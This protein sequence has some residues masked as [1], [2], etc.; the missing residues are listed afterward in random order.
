MKYRFFARGLAILLL[1][2]S[3][4]MAA[5][6]ADVLPAAKQWAVRPLAEIMRHQAPALDREVLA[7]EDLDRRDQGLP[8]R[9]AQNQEVSLTPDAAGNWETLPGGR[10]LWR[11]RVFCP[12]V[13]SLNLGF[14]R[15]WLPA[16]ARLLVYPAAEPSPVQVYDETDIA[17][18][19]QLWT[20]VLLTDE[21]VIELEVDAALRWQVEI[22]LTSIG[23]GYRLFGEDFTEKSG[24]CNVD[25]VC[26]EGDDWRDEID[27]VGGYSFGGSLFCTGFMINNTDQDGT[28]Y[29]MTAY[30]CDVR[31]NLAP[32]LVVYWNFQKPDCSMGSGSLTQFQNGATLRAEYSVS[33]MALLELDDL[34]ES[35]FNV[36]Y[37]GWN[38]ATPPPT[39]AVCIHHPSG[40]EKSIS[41]END[42]VT[43][44]SYQ[45]NLS[46]GDGTHLRV[47]DWDVGT[48][49]P[50]SSGSPLF[51]QDHRVVGQ[52]H[53]GAAACGNNASDWYGRF[54]T[55]WTGGGTPATQLSGWLDPQDTGA[56]TVDTI[57]PRGTSFTVAP[58]AGFESA[59]VQG[60]TFEPMSMV[61]TL[62]NTGDETA[63]FTAE[64]A[65]GW[66]TVTPAGGSIAIGGTVEVE[67]SFNSAADNLA[68]G[69]HQSTLLITNTAN[70]AGSTSRPVSVS[71]SSNLPSL[72]G[73]V[74]N[75]F[76]SQTVPETEIRYTLGGQAT[77]TG[78]IFDIR[79]QRV[80]DLGSMTGAAG[81]NHFTWDGSDHLGRSAPSGKYVFVL[82]ALGVEQRTNIILIR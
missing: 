6:G 20:G 60:G 25:V 42:P 65:N 51:D 40:D 43:V 38:R 15:F 11:L 36:K 70:G 44:T 27:T 77:V 61:Y 53:G 45:S 76:G 64:V 72:T 80:Q 32:S 1:V 5:F 16:G 48:T 8:F 39:S 29:F 55:S 50:G 31:A 71:V 10:S 47:D 81:E 37:A 3:L 17:D 7:R 24:Y 30:H 54:F 62:T 63:Q 66:L 26:E 69:R 59:G 73:V 56:Q 41:F 21:A 46:P 33:D 12:D 79:G 2:I 34:P 82:K 49:E 75:P 78:Q 28:P 52:L 19:G 68:V 58:A 4:P 23:R 9:F 22:E 57:D 74:P 14:S 67:V 13:L 18:H 35:D